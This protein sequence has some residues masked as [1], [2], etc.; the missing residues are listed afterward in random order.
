M[1]KFKNNN[2]TSTLD[3]LELY[4]S[5]VFDN[6]PIYDGGLFITAAI[7]ITNLYIAE[8]NGTI[9]YDQ[10]IYVNKTFIS[11][12]ENFQKNILTKKETSVSNKE[13]I[14]R[15]L[16][17]KNLIKKEGL[18]KVLDYAGIESY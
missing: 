16:N 8:I 7:M 11:M 14:D 17:L 12:Y 5:V 13:I 15:L 2:E 6:T 18:P 3:L 4:L 9:N 1:T 10:E